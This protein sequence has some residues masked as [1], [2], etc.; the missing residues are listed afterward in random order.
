MVETLP[1]GGF[2]SHLKMNA[3]MW[4]VLNVWTTMVSCNYSFLAVLPLFMFT[5][6]EAGGMGLG[7]VDIGKQS[8]VSPR[9]KLK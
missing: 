9:L 2:T 7:T 6:V 8:S 4:S 1:A 3:D 5:P